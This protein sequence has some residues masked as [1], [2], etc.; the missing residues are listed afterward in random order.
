MI[1]DILDDSSRP[2]RS[3]RDIFHEASI[4][5]LKI[6]HKMLSRLQETEETEPAE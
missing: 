4:D 3:P 2:Y 1:A 5:D 6:L